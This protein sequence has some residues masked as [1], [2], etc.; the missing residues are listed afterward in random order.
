MAQSAEEG[1]SLAWC[2]YRGALEGGLS[3]RR[4]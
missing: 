4:L 2:G 1:L 3:E